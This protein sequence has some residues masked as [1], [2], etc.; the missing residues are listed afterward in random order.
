MAGTS[1]LTA[2]AQGHLEDILMFSGVSHSYI[3]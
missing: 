3:Q 1:Y 2:L